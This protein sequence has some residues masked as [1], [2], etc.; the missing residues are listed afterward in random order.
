MFH[1]VFTDLPDRICPDSIYC[2][3]QIVH[4]GEPLNSS[5]YQ[6]QFDIKSNAQIIQG[7]QVI[8]QAT[9][10]I[11]FNPGFEVFE[12]ATLEVKLAGCREENSGQIEIIQ[13]E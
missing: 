13:Q 2:P 8:Y 6:A 1:L 10:Q 7:S 4:L 9:Q 3:D 12:G 5:K 11:L